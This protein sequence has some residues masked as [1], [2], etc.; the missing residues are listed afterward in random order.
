VQTPVVP[1]LDGVI[2]RATGW[3]SRSAAMLRRRRDRAAAIRELMKLDD[4][5]LEDAGLARHELRTL[6]ESR[7]G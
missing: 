1:W 7:L 5:L 6:I 3:L 4:H 2:D